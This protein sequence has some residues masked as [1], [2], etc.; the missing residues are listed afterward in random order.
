MLNNVEV[1]F[2]TPL[3]QG[4]ENNT[5][6][7]CFARFRKAQVNSRRHPLLKMENISLEPTVK[8]ALSLSLPFD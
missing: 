7:E 1:V 8:S 4:E 3:L 5:G 6:L 2:D